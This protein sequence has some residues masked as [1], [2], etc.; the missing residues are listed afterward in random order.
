MEENQASNGSNLDNLSTDTEKL[1]PQSHVNQIVQHAKA[2]AAESA[3]REAQEEYNHQLAAMQAD[4]EKRNLGQIPPTGVNQDDLIQKV[5]ERIVA[6][7]QASQEAQYQQAIQ[8]H[9]QETWDTFN[10]KMQTGPKDY[11]DF[12]AVMKDFNPAAYPELVYLATQVDHTPGV[13]HELVG[14][15]LKLGALDRLAEKDPV[16]AKAELLKLSKSIETNLKA[17][18]DAE[19]QHTSEPLDHLQ[20]SHVSG[21]SGNMSVSDY[22]NLPWLR[23]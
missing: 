21:S 4:M 15:P 19:S 14:N 13:M 11:E 12:D 7:A 2:K 1:L 5:T 3:K 18:A 20:P 16:R 22:R 8:K 17:K 9:A 23:G 10:A 6:Q